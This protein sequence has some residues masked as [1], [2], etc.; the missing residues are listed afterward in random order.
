MI[1]KG[2]LK[3]L[4]TSVSPESSRSE[5]SSSDEALFLPMEEEEEELLASDSSS[6]GNSRSQIETQWMKLDRSMVTP[7]LL[8]T[9]NGIVSAESVKTENNN[10]KKKSKKKKKNS[11]K[12]NG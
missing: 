6:S 8:P 12:W 4:C 7:P 3:E 1:S 10:K 5:E 2:P 9:A 11:V